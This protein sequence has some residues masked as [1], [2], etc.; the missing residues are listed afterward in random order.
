MPHSWHPAYYRPVG[1][2]HKPH[3]P[4]PGAAA[5]AGRQRTANIGRIDLLSQAIIAGPWRHPQL[6]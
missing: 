2:D 3:L 4:L 6:P 1:Y 5:A